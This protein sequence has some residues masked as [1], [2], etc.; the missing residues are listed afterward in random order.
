[1]DDIRA[2]GA[3]ATFAEVSKSTLERFRVL[4][5]PL[6]EQRRIAA[7]LREQQA[8]IDR[9]ASAS[10]A[11]IDEM[12]GLAQRAIDAAI[13]PSDATVLGHTLRTPLRTGL[14]RAASATAE[15]RVLTL[16]SVR[17]GVLDVNQNRPTD[18]TDAEALA[19]A[20]R[21]STF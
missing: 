10:Q 6:D 1:M 15:H 8:E 4:F 9:V 17:N 12:N 16:S 7:R 13:P 18:A 20:M 5:P 3:G 11:R 2:L 14:S 21:P 19:N